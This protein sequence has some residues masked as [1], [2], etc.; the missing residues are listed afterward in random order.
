MGSSIVRAALALS[1]STAPAEAAAP[2]TT[3]PTAPSAPV[4]AVPEAPPEALQNVSYRPPVS[5]WIAAGVAAGLF[6]T[7][8]AFTLTATSVEQKAGT[9]NANGVDT[10]LTRARAVQGLNDVRI[11]NT[12]LVGAGLALV[13]AVTFAVLHAH[14]AAEALAPPAPD[15]PLALQW[16]LP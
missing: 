8:L 9:L 7:G 15:H 13:A 5:T 2:T 11:G 4:S 6:A 14:R 3:E 12:L 16:T 10:G 1:L